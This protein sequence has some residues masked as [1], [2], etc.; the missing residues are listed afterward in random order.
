MR[1]KKHERA[2]ERILEMAKAWKRYVK[3]H[4]AYAQT[5]AVAVLER[6][7]EIIIEEC[8]KYSSMPLKRQIWHEKRKEGVRVRRG[9]ANL[10]GADMN[11]GYDAELNF[12]IA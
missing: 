9:G 7:A 8:G 11:A 3:C 4:D 6:A 1:M 10:P 2:I 5:I 12:D